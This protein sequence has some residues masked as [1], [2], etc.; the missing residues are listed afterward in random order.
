M[1]PAPSAGF[2]RLYGTRI[3]LLLGFVAL[4]LG[5]AVFRLSR[6]GARLHREADAA[7]ARG[8]FYQA[9]ALARGAAETA[10]STHAAFGMNLLGRLAQESEARGDDA[11]ALFCFRAQYG[12]ALSTASVWNDQASVRALAKA[13][14]LRVAARRDQKTPS[15]PAAGGAGNAQAANEGTQAAVRTA[16]GSREPQGRGATLLLALGA[17]AMV[18]ALGRVRVQ[19]RTGLAVA[20]ATGLLGVALASVGLLLL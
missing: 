6:E 18:F 11:L 16:L 5:G 1:N 12:A 7:M 20:A 10:P 15:P 2:G 14:L 9:A 8:D 17:V 13:G 3:A 19:P 4:L